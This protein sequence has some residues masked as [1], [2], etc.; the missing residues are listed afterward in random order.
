MS[1]LNQDYNATLPANIYYDLLISNFDNGK[2]KPSSFHYN[3]NGDQ[4]FL[5][6]PEAYELSI[7]KFQIDT[8]LCPVFIPSIVRNQADINLTIYSVNLSSVDADGNDVFSDD[9]PIMWSPQDKTASLP[10]A[11]NETPDGFS[12]NNSG[13][14]FCY[15]YTYFNKLVQDA[16]NLAFENLKAKMGTFT[17]TDKP[18]MI[19]WDSPSDTAV[20]YVPLGSK[21]SIYMNSALF[22]LFNSFPFTL[23]EKGYKLIV[24]TVEGLNTQALNGTT[25]TVVQQE[26]SSL[27]GWSPFTAIVFTSNTLPI[28][29][30]ML[31]NPRIYSNNQ[32]ISESARSVPE[33]IITDLTSS[34]GVYKGGISYVPSAQYRKITLFGNRPLSNI[35]LNVYFRSKYGKL[36]PFRMSSGGSITLKLL[37]E[38]IKS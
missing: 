12:D 21:Y 1:A 33:N 32:I 36:L 19:F 22:S 16:Y 26:G 11:T 30:N 29:S 37:F 3:A 8:G 28:Q 7:I 9:I 18:P 34:D 25:Y 10:Q 20:F 35:D 6:N 4:P 38:K 2:E 17:D 15:N 27:I 14:Y 23:D 13:Y 24:N 5:I 31:N